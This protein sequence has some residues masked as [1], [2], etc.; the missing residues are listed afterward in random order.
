[1]LCSLYPFPAR[2]AAGG[3]DV[4]DRLRSRTAP[5]SSTPAVVPVVALLETL[6]EALRAQ[7]LDIEVDYCVENDGVVRLAVV[8]RDL[9]RDMTLGD[10]IRTGLHLQASTEGTVPARVGERLFRVACANGAIVEFER[11]QAATLQASAWRPTLESVVARCFSTA[12]LDRDAAR[13]RATTNQMLVAPYELLCHLAA[14]RLVSDAEQAA[15]QREFHEAG[16]ATLYGFINAVTRVAWRLRE[17]DGWKRSIELERLGG[18]ILR[19]DH[20]PPVG[21]LAY[22]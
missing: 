13:F 11:A 2:D 7:R 22:R 15:I 12:G 3:P 14:R 4:I 9:G 18:D 19:G 17:S 16:D 8:A 20:Q 10:T 5:A 1:V 6:V 21:E